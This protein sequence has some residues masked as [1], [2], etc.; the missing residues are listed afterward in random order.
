MH[1]GA[2]RLQAIDV[3]HHPLAVAEDALAELLVDAAVAAGTGE[4]AALHAGG[5]RVVPRRR[6]QAGD[7][8]SAVF[9]LVMVMSAGVA[10]RTS[11]LRPG[12]WSRSRSPWSRSPWSPGGQEACGPGWWSR[13]WSPW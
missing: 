1:R 3:A 10:R 11:R 6:D 7:L 9:A 8:V 4:V 2:V 13:S 12:W 5:V